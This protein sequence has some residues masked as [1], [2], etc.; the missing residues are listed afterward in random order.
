[1]EDR[2][3]ARHDGCMNDTQQPGSGTAGPGASDT[4]GPGASHTAGPGQ[5]SSDRDQPGFEPHRIRSITDMHRSRSDALL[6]GVCTGAAKYLNVDPVIVRIAF[7]VLT[8]IG[9]A[10][11]ILY[12]AA[13]FLLPPEGGTSVAAE[14][15]NLDD[16]EERVRVGGMVV[17]SVVAVLAVVGDSG[18]GW[19]FPWWIFPIG[20]LVISFVVLKNRRRDHE[21]VQ[22]VDDPRLTDPAAYGEAI[23]QAKTERIMAVKRERACEPRSHALLG[24]TASVTAIALAITRLVADA[25]GGTG[26]ATYVAVALAVVGLGVLVSTFVGDG[27]ILILIGFVLAAALAAGSALPSLRTG[28]QTQ[29]PETAMAVESTYQHGIGT[30]VV[31]LT[32]VQNPQAL[33]GR[34]VHVESGI[35]QTKIIVPTDLDVAVDAELSGGEIRIF[36]RKANGTNTE[37]KVPAEGPRHLTIDIEHRLGNIEVIRK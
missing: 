17:A 1:M 6:G 2:A 3:I 26:H 29:Q 34:T 21:P 31:D 22:P 35:G 14:W 33:L 32:D 20:V 5:D 23:A 11:L 25:N 30:L 13:W 4:A 19:G 18:W 9:G 37:L 12:V 24:L 7:A 27:G 28:E 10:G 36:D 15:F 8:F 16:N